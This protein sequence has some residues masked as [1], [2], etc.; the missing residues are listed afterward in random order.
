MGFS[1]GVKMKWINSKR[2]FLLLAGFLF[3]SSALFSEVCLTDAE[4]QELSDNL[5][6]LETTLI[7]QEQQLTRQ[8]KQLTA[9]RHL[10]TISERE[11]LSLKVSYKEAEKYWQ[12]RKIEAVV[13]TGSCGILLGF[14][15]HFLLPGG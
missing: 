14:L 7:Q 6:Q 2:I 10:I 9:A 5:T 3:L 11:I 12:K 1:L 8:A 13:L 15:I 4:A